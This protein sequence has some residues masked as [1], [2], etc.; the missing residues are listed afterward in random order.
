MLSDD[1][2]VRALMLV[3]LFFGVLVSLLLLA[4]IEKLAG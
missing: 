4:L 2:D 1:L 3:G